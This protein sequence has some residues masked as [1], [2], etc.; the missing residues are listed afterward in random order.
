MVAG[1]LR[2]ATF[3]PGMFS[4]G[5]FQVWERDIVHYVKEIQENTWHISSDPGFVS[6]VAYN[7]EIG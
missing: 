4:Q 2:L 3:S 6:Y 5:D 1:K 7:E